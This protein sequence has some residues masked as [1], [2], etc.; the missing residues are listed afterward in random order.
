ML[1]RLLLS[2]LL[3][4]LCCTTAHAAED[5]LNIIRYT[6]RKWG[7]KQARLYREQLELALQKLSQLPNSGRRREEIASGVRS[8]RVAEHIAFFMP[9]KGGI[10]ILRLLHPSMDVE[11][12]FDRKDDPEP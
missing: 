9:R 10:T 6:K 1:H 8:F 5:L 3:A 11:L 12:A 2:S 7:L 4:A